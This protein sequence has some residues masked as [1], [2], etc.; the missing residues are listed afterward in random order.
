MKVRVKVMYEWTENL[1]RMDAAAMCDFAYA[2]GYPPKSEWIPL[3][4]RYHEECPEVPDN[5]K[6]TV[7]I[8]K[9]T[10][11]RPQKRIP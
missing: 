6:V 10:S 1:K 7:C 3:L 11:K 8:T 5:A 2:P 4:K 9:A